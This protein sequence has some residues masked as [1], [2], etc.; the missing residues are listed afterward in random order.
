MKRITVVAIFALASILGAGS[1]LAQ[2]QS[3]EV[4]ATVPF[5][6]TVGNKLL[7]AGTYTVAPAMDGEAV[8]IQSRKGH[9]VV[10]SLASQN[11]NPSAGCALNFD[12]RDGQYFMRGVLC[13]S[14]AMSVNLPA[15]RLEARAGAEEAKLNIDDGQVMIAA[16]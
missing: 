11:G 5:D 9:L 1:A 13:G 3:K 16:K 14:S 12:R 10:I 6:F 7:P 4:Q 8:Q 2:V 15:S